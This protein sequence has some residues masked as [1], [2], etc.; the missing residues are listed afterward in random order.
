MI[1]MRQLKILA[2]T[3]G[4]TAA[5]LSCGSV[6]RNGSSP[7]FLVVN[8]LHGAPGTPSGTPGSASAGP[9]F[10]NVQNTATTSPPCPAAIPPATT[11][12]CQVSVSDGGV[13]Q[14]AL[15]QKNINTTGTTAAPSTNNEVT[16]TRY[17]VTYTRADG[18]NTPGVDVPLAF[19]GVVTTIIPIGNTPVSVPFELVRIVA[20]EEP[21][22]AALASSPTVLTTIA[23]IT[24]Y[25]QDLVGNA[26]S[27][28]GT[29]QI[30][31]GRFGS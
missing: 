30:D 10:S 21:P 3:F 29:I 18:R 4:V 27:A 20:K 14:L 25:G 9:L 1:A 15:V 2:A 31:F 28:T 26:I 24:F 23:T 7:M 13:A 17:H 5:S 6:V 19:D 16:I 8:T 22:L 12:T 11:T